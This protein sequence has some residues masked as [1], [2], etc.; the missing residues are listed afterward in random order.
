MLA[1]FEELIFIKRT[2]V[3][4]CDVSRASLITIY[5]AICL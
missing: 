5:H 4:I 2:I 3:F 1:I